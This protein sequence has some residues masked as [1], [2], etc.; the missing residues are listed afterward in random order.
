MRFRDRRD[1]GRRLGA[2]VAAEPLTPPA[3]ERSPDG[4]IVVLAVPRGGVPVGFEVAAAL[5][6]P[7]DVFVVRKIGVPWHPELGVGALA[8]GGEPLLAP[9]T[10]RATG[11]TPADLEPVIARERVELARRVERYRGGRPLPRLEGRDVVVVDDGL[12]TGVSALAALHALRLRSPR[13]LVL[14]VPVAAPET[15]ARVRD[16]GVADAVVCVLAP[17]EFYAVG[18]WYERFD[19]TTDD[20]VLTLLR[21][22]RRGP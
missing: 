8:E 11:V 21:E 3:A 6:A 13:R 10:L 17:P 4:N 22:S 20:E 14:A 2:L 19:Q 5:G 1:A 9:E 7:L 16:S 18:A 12:A 15:V